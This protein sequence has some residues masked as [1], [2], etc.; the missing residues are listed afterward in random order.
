MLEV[1]A[2]FM[3]ATHT[4]Y[5]AQHFG[6][7]AKR[8]QGWHERPHGCTVLGRKGDADV[9][10]Q[11]RAVSMFRTHG[12]EVQALAGLAQVERTAGGRG[13]GSSSRNN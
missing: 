7:I 3:G 11:L 5:T 13:D 2:F 9:L 8:K 1:Q 6:A 10:L 4:G 12:V